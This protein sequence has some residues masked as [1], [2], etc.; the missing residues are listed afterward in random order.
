MNGQVAPVRALHGRGQDNRCR[1]CDEIETLGHVL[2]FCDRGYL[3]RNTR[4]NT[5]RTLI[6]DE[7]RR[8]KWNVY[9]EVH[10]INPSRSTQRIDILIYK[11]KNDKSYILDPTIR[12]EAG[13]NQSEDVNIEKKAHYDSVIPYCKQKY[14][15]A[16]IEVIGLFI[17][18]RGTIT[19]D[20][21][22]FRFK[23]DLSKEMRNNIAL[24]V[25][26]SSV[27]RKVNYGRNSQL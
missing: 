25:I 12:F 13:G 21:E 10:C 5:V 9:E 14:K 11:N 6:A 15:L 2:G 27:Q 26:K 4:H 22:N 20:F 16:D 7:F 17:G 18:A 23:F 24:S 3:L 1:H 8:L 19:V